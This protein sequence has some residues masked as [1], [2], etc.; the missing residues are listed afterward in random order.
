VAA[1]AAAAVTAA[2]VTE[3]QNG[4]IGISKQLGKSQ[5]IR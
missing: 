2:A 4:T 3:N 1:A 5:L